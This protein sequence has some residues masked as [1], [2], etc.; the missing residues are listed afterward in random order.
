MLYSLLDPV[1]HRPPV[2]PRLV[3]VVAESQQ[4]L[5]TLCSYFER[6]GIAGNAARELG[7]VSML[8]TDATSLV[9]FPDGFERL[10]VE[11]FVLALRRARPSLL[12]LLVSS[13]PQH[14]GAALEPDGSS[15]P[16]LVLPRPAFG[17]TILDAIRERGLEPNA[18]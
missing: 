1:V 15:L 17:W 16:P 3:T 9:L 11:A 7:D 10:Q 8:A 18:D 4:T 5:D 14:L 6:V 12:I 13:A 2:K